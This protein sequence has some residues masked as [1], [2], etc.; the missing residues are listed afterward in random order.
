MKRPTH[1]YWTYVSP[2]AIDEHRKRPLLEKLRWLEELLRFNAAFLPARARRD[3]A[4][5]REGRI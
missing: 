1:G 2:E 5:F 3:Q 4:L